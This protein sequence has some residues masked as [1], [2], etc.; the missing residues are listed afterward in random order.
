MFVGSYGLLENKNKFP[1]FVCLMIETS[2]VS[3]IEQ[4]SLVSQK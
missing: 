4:R 3:E 1:R 2:V